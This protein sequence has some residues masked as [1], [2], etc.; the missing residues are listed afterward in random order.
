MERKHINMLINYR[1]IKTIRKYVR[2]EKVRIGFDIKPI[3]SF[4]KT[5]AILHNYVRSRRR[6]KGREREK[7]QN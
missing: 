3:T 5:N 6:V 7:N 2:S 4:Y 1:F